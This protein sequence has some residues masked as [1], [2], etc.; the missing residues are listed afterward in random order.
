MSL[1]TRMAETHQQHK[2]LAKNMWYRRRDE[3]LRARS[4]NGKYNAFR[5]LDHTFG[6]VE[7]LFI[8]RAAFELA[9]TAYDQKA[10]DGLLM[11]SIERT[12]VLNQSKHQKPH[13]RIAI[14]TF[15]ANLPLLTSIHIAR[16]HP[17]LENL[18]RTHRTSAQSLSGAIRSRQSDIG[19]TQDFVGISSEAVALVL[20]QRYA[21][22]QIG[23]SGWTP[24]P[25]LLGQDCPPVNGSHLSRNWD[26]S[27]YATEEIADPT[28]KLQVKYGNVHALY[29][30]DI[31][32]AKLK[33]DLT[34]NG[35]E[36]TSLRKL[37]TIATS[38]V[39]E[40]PL[41]YMTEEVEPRTA[42]LLDILDTAS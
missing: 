4:W 24:V 10:Q 32:V 38:H 8:A 5:T 17:S 1:Q 20:L 23:E 13:E 11:E 40:A 42:K 6:P 9:A 18:E 41:R 3:Y 14:A 25:S 26:V 35:E 33:T 29:T 31:A 12:T 19:E 16:E 21:T 34:I 39:V 7:P 22:E 37:M 36:R 27:I 28:H 15:A 2:K 30:D